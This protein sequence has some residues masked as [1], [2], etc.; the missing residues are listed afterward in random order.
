MVQNKHFFAILQNILRENNVRPSILDLPYPLPRRGILSP[1]GQ[2]PVG[3]GAMEGAARRWAKAGG[4]LFNPSI[5]QSLNPLLYQHLAS[6]DD[7]DTFR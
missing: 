1:K 3:S 6:V 2:S 4:G 7:V 5:L